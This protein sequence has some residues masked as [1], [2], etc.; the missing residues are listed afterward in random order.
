[1]KT[2]NLQKERK[3]N[4]IK[5]HSPRIRRKFLRFTRIRIDMRLTF[6]TQ[7]TNEGDWK[8][9][10]NQ[11]LSRHL[12]SPSSF[13]PTYQHWNSTGESSVRFFS[14]RLRD[15]ISHTV[16][17]VPSALDVLFAWIKTRSRRATSRRLKKT[18][19]NDVRYFD[20]LLTRDDDASTRHT[21]WWINRICLTASTF[22]V[23]PLVV[24]WFQFVF[25]LKCP[26]RTATAVYRKILKKMKTC[27]TETL[28]TRSGR[29]VD[30]VYRKAYQAC[31]TWW[32]LS[33]CVIDNSH[34]DPFQLIS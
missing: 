4:Y 20:L 16:W 28:L 13:S 17:I 10:S 11:L 6:T 19:T 33:R 8:S 32:A 26:R 14:G 23:R 3:Q 34:H 7:P 5:T 22:R 30:L 15:A 25:S 24:L 27:R 21:A 31:W 2:K 12:K 18:K 29:Y 9:S 1:M